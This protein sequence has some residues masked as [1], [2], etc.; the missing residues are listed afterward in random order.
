MPH[1]DLLERVAQHVRDYVG[2]TREA[3]SLPPFVAYFHPQYAETWFNFA[4]PAGRIVPEAD[5]GASLS[6]LR[7]AFM[8]R[9]RP[10]RI[11]FVGELWPDLPNAL[12]RSGMKRDSVQTILVCRPGELR[13]RRRPGIDVR[14][15]N[16]DD[17][18]AVLEQWLRV[19]HESFGT[20]AGFGGTAADEIAY[21]RSKLRTDVWRGAVAIENG[22]FVGTGTTLLANGAGELAAIGTLPAHRRRGVASALTTFLVED[23]YARGGELAWLGAGDAAARQA[24]EGIGFQVIGTQVVFSM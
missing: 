21:A 8:L 9:G 5:L 1:R 24:Y 10:L 13:P 23:F 11:E 18:D 20:P 22:A 14:L 6:K 7:A 2:L 12:E 15:L 4:V 17:E 19:Q 16:A 3:V